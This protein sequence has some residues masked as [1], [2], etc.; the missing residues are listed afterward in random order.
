MIKISFSFILMLF[1]SFSL[2]ANK[3]IQAV[4]KGGQDV[5]LYPDGT[6]AFTKEPP[7]YNPP[8]LTTKIAI[9]KQPATLPPPPRLT[10]T[11]LRDKRGIYEIF[12]N[13]NLWKQNNAA[14]KDAAIQLKHTKE[15]AYAM[16]IF[17]STP[18]SLDDLK[19]QAL[20]NVRQ[21]A[22]QA[23]IVS[24]EKKWINGHEMMILKINSSMGGLL[25]SYLNYYATGDW[26]TIQFVTYI[27]TA[28][29]PKYEADLI[30]L[31]N[32]LTIK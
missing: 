9:P 6:W 22:T 4:T 7:L 25:V 28:L 11:F 32:G 29:L 31:L 2:H 10:K 3:D 21:V 13:N 18:I 19:T 8:Q 26:G 16:V 27:E 24:A 1:A 30:G 20:T 17:E 15:D 14:N 12:Y 23:E 5:I